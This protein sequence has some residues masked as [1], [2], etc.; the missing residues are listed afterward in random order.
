[1]KKDG[2][3]QLQLLKMCMFASQ[4]SS[5]FSVTAHLNSLQVSWNCLTVRY[6]M[7]RWASSYQPQNTEMQCSITDNCLIN[8]S[9]LQLIKTPTWPKQSNSLTNPNKCSHPNI[10]TPSLFGSKCCCFLLKTNFNVSD[11]NWFNILL[12]SL[13]S[14]ARLSCPSPF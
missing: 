3:N 10:N 1:M 7:G 11:L 8:C 14:E 4:Y 13:T 12:F 6:F 2:L 5:S 9:L